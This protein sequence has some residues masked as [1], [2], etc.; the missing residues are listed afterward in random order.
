MKEMPE[1]K[2]FDLVAASMLTDT[3]LSERLF[4][5]DYKV[6]GNLSHWAAK[7]PERYTAARQIARTKGKLG[8]TAHEQI[9]AQY[10]PKERRYSDEELRVRTKYSGREQELKDFFTGAS[11]TLTNNPGTLA[12]ENPTEYADRVL[13]ARSTG[14]VPRPDESEAW[15][16]ERSD[17]SLLA[18][19]IADRAGLPRGTKVT[20]D[21]A[22]KIIQIIADAEQ[23]KE[24]H[25]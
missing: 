12:K 21:E 5:G 18:D 24:Q 13:W 1:K 20:G 17:T 22:L 3:E 8:Q 9:R 10:G 11:A 6:I 19:E 23:A 15:Q 7:N 16:Q 14:L 4:S 2:H 25:A